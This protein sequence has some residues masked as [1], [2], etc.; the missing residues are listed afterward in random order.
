ML[1]KKQSNWNLK[2]NWID[3]IIE[4]IED[5]I[6]EREYR[7]IEVTQSQQKEKTH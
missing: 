7:T 5:R 6:S 2:T 3:S 4:T 1:Y